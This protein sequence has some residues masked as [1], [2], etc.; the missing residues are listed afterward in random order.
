MDMD[1]DADTDT[2]TDTGHGKFKKMRTR[3]R[4]GCH[5][6]G[7]GTRLVRGLGKLIQFKLLII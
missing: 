5:A 4:L 6:P 3:T 2:D 7:F 1:T